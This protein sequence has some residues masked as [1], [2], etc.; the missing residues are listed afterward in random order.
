MKAKE[1]KKA[2][3]AWSMYD[4]ANSAFATTIMAGFMP[5]YFKELAKS[6]GMSEVGS[7]SAWAYV[8]TIALIIIALLA[9][10][11]GYM[12]DRMGGKKRFLTIFAVFGAIA[13]IALYIPNGD[14][15]QLAG[16]I[17][18]LGNLGFAGAN[19]FANA[20]LPHVAK[21]EDIDQVSVKGYALGYLGGGLLL[22]INV[23]M[24]LKP[25]LFGIPDASLAVRLSFVTVGFWWLGFTIPLWK[26]VKEPETVYDENLK[27]GEAFKSSFKEL[28]KTFNKIKQY[29]EAFKLLLAFWLYNDGI[30]TIIKMATAYGAEIGLGLT[31]MIGAL[32]LVQFVGIPF[33]FAFGWLAKKIGAKNSILIALVIYTFI[34][35]GG[36][37]MAVAWHF[38]TL[39]FLVALVQGGA[40]ALSR[41]LFGSMIPKS[42]SGEFFGF[43]SMSDKFAGI[44]GPFVFASAGLLLG[45]SRFGIVSLV[46]FF[47]L[48]G[49]LLLKVDTKKGM[50][51]ARLAEQAGA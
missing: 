43:F 31:E 8:T 12:A 49:I 9:P 51:T 4:W 50:E 44:A 3:N 39:A 37:F 23:L 38:W 20:L 18:I 30:G 10:A 29:P 15:F 24:F 2:V 48:G 27:F 25:E 46:I 45:S 19:I 16:A 40:Q 7:T 47:V 14:M 13:S 41:S 42:R 34:S 1:Y 33:S 5:G 32:A 35:I 11:M 26:H 21:E 6:A 36:Y 28:A 17:Y 22:V